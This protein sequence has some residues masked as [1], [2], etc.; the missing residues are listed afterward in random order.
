MPMPTSIEN[1]QKNGI[2]L[3]RDFINPKF[4]ERY[5]SINQNSLNGGITRRLIRKLNARLLP[6]KKLENFP[7]AIR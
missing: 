1:M 5:K 3:S 7:R 6:E 4:Q 2:Y